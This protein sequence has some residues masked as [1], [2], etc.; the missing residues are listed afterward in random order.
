MSSD[1]WVIYVHP[2]GS[3]DP[4]TDGKLY[5]WAA[6][7]YAV[8]M[9]GGSAGGLQ[10]TTVR[11]IVAQDQLAADGAIIVPGEGRIV[12]CMVERGGKHHFLHGG[13]GIV[14]DS[15]AYGQSSNYTGIPLVYFQP[16]SGSLPDLPV[17][18]ERYGNIK[19]ER[20][21]LTTNAHVGFK[22][23]DIRYCWAYASEGPFNSS[24]ARF[25]GVYIEECHN[26]VRNTNIE[27]IGGVLNGFG[28]PD[29][30]SEARG[31]ITI[32]DSLIANQRVTRV[33]LS[34]QSVTVENSVIISQGK[35]VFEDDRNENPDVILNRCIVVGDPVDGSSTI[36]GGDDCIFVSPNDA[37]EVWLGGFRG[38]LSDL[39]SNTG[40]F[41]NSV[42]CTMDQ[43]GSLFQGDYLK[44]DVR[45]S[46][47]ATVTDASGSVLSTL[48]DG[49]LLQDIGMQ[50][51]PDFD[52][53]TM[54]DGALPQWITPPKTQQEGRDFI[55]DPDSH[56]WQKPVS[57]KSEDVNLGASL[58]GYYEM[59]NTGDEPDQ[60]GQNADLPPL[61]PIAQKS[62][63]NW[64]YREC[65]DGG[66][67]FVIDV[68]NLNG[69]LD[70]LPN[71]FWLAV[72]LRLRSNNLISG[73]VISF[74]RASKKRSFKI[75][76]DKS[77]SQYDIELHKDSGGPETF[78]A[79][80]NVGDWQI[81]QLWVNHVTGERGL[82]IDDT[83]TVVEPSSLSPMSGPRSNTDFL[84]GSNAPVDVG[85]LMIAD[86]SPDQQDRNWLYNGGSY[87]SLSAVQGRTVTQEVL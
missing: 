42:F 30:N 8:H 74:W 79:P 66:G 84:I 21:Y 49:T 1:P 51:H 2:T 15:V 73:T 32:R 52:A 26:T 82:R 23:A 59:S 53:K 31:D 20:P 56:N 22:P 19:T 87:R 6:R 85:P 45:V 24:G 60:T 18:V 76:Y 48:P 69:P 34:S 28:A 63:T 62:A 57:R 37:N 70:S 58:L 4:S 83:E 80:D 3:T 39:Q 50:R 46:G 9:G 68:S 36:A 71:R 29:S 78:T 65:V 13:D 33:P 25:E 10:P 14:K 86:V 55:A 43:L 72:P 64:P 81:F 40:A 44:G 47:N 11:G 16:D 7:D 12:Q 61:Q 75:Y 35:T 77:N 17:T 54:V 27:L 67:R 41:G 38:T 5:E